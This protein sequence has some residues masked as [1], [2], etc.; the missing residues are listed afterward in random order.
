MNRLCFGLAFAL[1]VVVAFAVN[2]PLVSADDIT[3]GT[4][5]STWNYPLSIYYHDARTQ[6]IYLASEIGQA[7][8]I[9]GL[10][11]DVYQVPGQTMNFFTIR[12]KHTHASILIRAGEDII[13]TSRRLGH[14]RPSVTLDIYGHIIPAGRAATRIWCE[15]VSRYM[16]E[17]A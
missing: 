14:S 1:V 5:T 9:N 4:G 10:S 16:P 3:I 8:S 6:T 13:T 7:C 17:P 11:L 15:A 2:S 12:M